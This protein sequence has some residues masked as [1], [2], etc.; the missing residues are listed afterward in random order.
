MDQE[1]EGASDT[2]GSGV[3]STA[4]P[5]ATENASTQGNVGESSPRKALSRSMGPQE[6][7]ELFVPAGIRITDPDEAQSLEYPN[8]GFVARAGDGEDI[9]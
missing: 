8:H 6:Q 9:G 4:S 2:L 7:N 5:P 3:A 1:S